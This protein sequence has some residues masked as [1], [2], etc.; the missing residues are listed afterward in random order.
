MSFSRPDFL[1]HSLFTLFLSL[2]L[3]IYQITSH[4]LTFFSL[5][6]F[7]HFLSHCLHYLSLFF[8]S[9]LAVLFVS[10]FLYFFIPLYIFFSF[11]SFF[12]FILLIF[13]FFNSL[14]PRYDLTFV[15]S[16][17][18]SLSCCLFLFLFIT[19]MF[20]IFLL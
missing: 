16:F 15:F 4:S 9:F 13:S 1:S 11:S 2:I 6:I 12:L 5:R 3:F 14:S 8:F 17:S 19:I 20:L 18:L 7:L 10:C